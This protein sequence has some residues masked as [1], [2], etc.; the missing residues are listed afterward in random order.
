MD[1]IVQMSQAELKHIRTALEVYGTT[2]VVESTQGLDN[3]TMDAET[4]LKNATL[5][6]RNLDLLQ[7]LDQH[8]K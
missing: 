6:M 3:G 2:I 7:T 5:L 8:V 1:F 4:A